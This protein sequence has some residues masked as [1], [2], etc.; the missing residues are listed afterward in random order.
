[1]HPNRRAVARAL[2]DKLVVLD[3][4]TGGYFELDA[5][6]ARIWQLIA[7]GSSLDEVVAALTDEFVVEPDEA[8]RDANAFLDD[9]R[10]HHLIEED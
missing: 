6:G 7:D 10:K 8:R 9:L 3:T 5:V 1:M 4:E 2:D